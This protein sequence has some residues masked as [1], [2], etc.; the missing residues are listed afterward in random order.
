MQIPCWQTSQKRTHCFSKHRFSHKQVQ[1]L[2]SK[3]HIKINQWHEFDKVNVQIQLLQC[4]FFYQKIPSLPFC[5]CATER[6]AWRSKAMDETPGGN[7]VEDQNRHRSWGSNTNLPGKMFFGV[8][9][10]S[11]FKLH[12]SLEVE[13][14]C[15]SLESLIRLHVVRGVQRV[16]WYGE[17]KKV[18]ALK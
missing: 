15:F 4:A 14:T 16:C 5:T 1:K 18:A 11:V 10:C 17:E 7:S 8:L 9:S 13:P 3:T 6:T 2:N 12:L